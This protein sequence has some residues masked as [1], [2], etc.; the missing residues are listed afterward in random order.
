[1]LQR[2]ATLLVTAQRCLALVLF[3]LG[4]VG[5]KVPVGCP[6]HAAVCVF[7]HL[8]RLAIARHAH[9]LAVALASACMKVRGAVQRSI[10]ESVVLSVCMEKCISPCF[11]HLSCLCLAPS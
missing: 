6:L 11:H 4:I 2:K 7:V 8:G 1:M 3:S 10:G 9:K 5:G